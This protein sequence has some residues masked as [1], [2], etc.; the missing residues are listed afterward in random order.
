MVLEIGEVELLDETNTVS[1]RRST[2]G[3]LLGSCSPVLT[4]PNRLNIYRI[5]TFPSGID[6][7][8]PW[9]RILEKVQVSCDVAMIR[10]KANT[11]RIALHT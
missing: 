7:F 3:R 2:H 11:K 4:L 5:S 10:N 8:G 6:L 9:T 1:T